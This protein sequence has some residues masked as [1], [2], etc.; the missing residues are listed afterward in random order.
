[1]AHGS[2]NPV[3]LAAAP[4]NTSIT[5]NGVLTA[6][7]PPGTPAVNRKKQ[8]RRQKQAA[9]LAAE[10][11]ADHEHE[12][13]QSIVGDP[14]LPAAHHSQM[15]HTHQSLYPQN[16][17]DVLDYEDQE[18]SQHDVYDEEG[19]SFSDEEG[20]AYDDGYEHSGTNGHNHH[21]HS[22]VPGGDVTR[23]KSKKKKKKT[24]ASAHTSYDP[25][26]H[27]Y[28]GGHVPPPPPPPPPPTNS[29]S[30]N[31]QRANKGDRIWNTSTQEERENIKEFWLSLGEDER[32]S[33]VKIE[34]EAV[35]RKMK[36]QQKHSCSCT[37]CGRKR[38]AIEEELEVLYDAYYEELEQ[39][40]PDRM[41]PLINPHEPSHGQIEEIADDEDEEDDEEDDEDYEDDEGNA[42]YDEEEDYDEEDS[43]EEPE[44]IHQSATEF[45]TF[46]NSLTV[47]GGILTVADDLLQ[48][49]G[50]KFIEMME[51]L[52]ERRMQ[53][54]E[55]AQYDANSH[56]PYQ[57]GGYRGHTHGGPDDDEFEDEE[58][59]EYD[60][61]E[62]FEEDDD[63]ADTMS[64]EQRMEEGRRMFQIFA[65]RMFE[66]RV[67]TAYREKIARERQQRLLEELDKEENEKEQLQAKK[68][69]EAEKRKQK[70]AAQ[71]Q[72]QAEEKAR[73]EAEKAAEEAAAKA[74]EAKRQEEL[75]RK[76]D[77]QK[78]KKEAEKKVAEEERQRK[79]LE[80]TRRQQEERDRHL[81]AERKAREQ[82]AA[83]K[84]AKEEMKRKE[85]ESREAKERDAKERKAQAERERRERE[86]RAKTEK[87]A[88]EKEAKESKEAQARKDAQT[89]QV[90]AQAGLVEASQ[91]QA[92][93][94]AQAAQAAQSKRTPSAAAIP[95]AP[96]LHKQP[97]SF[98]SPHFQV[99]T[100]TIPPKAP[101]PVRPRQSSQQG[102]KGSSP[103]TPHAGVDKTASPSN[104]STSSASQH[105]TVPGLRNIFIKPT[106][107]PP[108]PFLHTQPSSPMHPLAP[109]PGMP[110]PQGPPG[111]NMPTVS[112][113]F[114]GAQ[115]SLSSGLTQRTAMP[116]SGSLFSAHQPSIGAQ[117]RGYPSTSLPGPPPGISGLGT[118]PQSSRA[119]PEP[120]P[121]LLPP[122]SGA[123]LY[124]G[125]ARDIAPLTSALLQHSRQQSGSSTFDPPGV[126][127][128]AQPIQRPAPIQ[129]PSSVKPFDMLDSTLDT[130]DIGRHLGSSALLGDD[131]PFNLRGGDGRRPSGPLG[132]GR[133][134]SS[135]GSAFGGT[136]IYHSPQPMSLAQPFGLGSGS[137]Q[138]STWGTPSLS[139]GQTSLGGGSTWGHSPTNMWSS[140]SG[141]FGTLPGLGSIANSG[142]Q[143]P[144]A[145]QLRINICQACK[146]LSQH[147]A[148]FN[149]FHDISTILQM[150]KNSVQPPAELD[151]VTDLCDTEGMHLNGGGTFL[152]ETGATP[153]QIM[154]KWIPDVDYAQ[155]GRL[156]GLAGEVGSPMMAPSN[157]LPIGSHW[158]LARSGGRGQH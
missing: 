55:Q 80:R 8:K 111:L 130:D 41:S 141:G 120:P 54:E 95:V 16:A 122:M 60:S 131:E 72:K 123:P 69:R 91:A 129:R 70:K 24:S 18:Y 157:P 12:V 35:L 74:A 93:Q 92:A 2:K 57:D 62:E 43:D 81:E 32:K 45:F 119:Y 110:Y 125:N 15:R 144:R 76:R 112:S 152:V 99:A 78:K 1:M 82:K 63:D 138:S 9:K 19:V 97:S 68:A 114:T 10:R 142:S 84:R 13:P 147:D 133:G 126:L 59:E 7:N 132:L 31:S 151:E 117:Y 66:Q 98:A 135:I 107:Q 73:R 88:R 11:A 33:L 115:G 50:K 137:N 134:G 139:L 140:T 124:A 20:H 136:P 14:T 90:A 146:T 79:E 83:E 36:E 56:P 96:A 17:Q 64:S 25:H 150:V 121:G 38:T 37:V 118:L 94:N 75:R 77:E 109:P 105:A 153:S 5:S 4:A 6:G 51:Q 3:P 49:D 108:M 42:E 67:L 102:S 21:E 52:A 27:H 156:G 89:A 23:K 100:P 46:G 87:E 143:R 106:T 113:G 28:A 58:D 65:A 85:R 128:S 34:K 104:A 116:P 61:Q 39:L 103:R 53:R 154:V 44:L 149:G 29:T 48:N 86:E 127:G 71:K 47:K 101:T 145:Q 155:Q 148:S 26:H 40:P 30:R 22:G 158:N